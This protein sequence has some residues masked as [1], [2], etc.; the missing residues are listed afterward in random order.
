[1]HIDYSNSVKKKHIN[2][3]K[4]KF[5]TNINQIKVLNFLKWYILRR[6]FCFATP[7]FKK[8]NFLLSRATTQ[9]MMWNWKKRSFFTVTPCILQCRNHP[10]QLLKAAAGS[11]K[12]PVCFKRWK[13]ATKILLYLNNVNKFLFCRFVKGGLHY[14]VF[15]LLNSESSASCTG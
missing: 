2:T 11:F 13:F 5:Q 10:E 15:Y 9:S 4:R 8:T 6:I 12:Y 3:I 1:M 14:R 7:K